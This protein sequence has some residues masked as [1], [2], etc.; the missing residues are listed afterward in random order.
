MHYV[1]VAQQAVVEMESER[2]R[3]ALLAAISHDVRTPLTALIGA[4]R[5]AA[6]GRAAADRDAARDWRSAIVDAGARNCNALVSNLL[7]MAR[8]RSGAVSLNCSATGNRSRRSW[9]RPSARP[10]ALA[11]TPVQT[12]LPADLP[13]V[14][15]DAVLIE[16]VLVN[17]L[18]NAAK[19]A[20]GRRSSSAPRRP[21]MRW[22]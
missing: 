9:A 7:D 11:D 12:E 6:D 16:R 20:R 8:L 5:V 10:A 14:E 19:Y 13:L 2:L 1:D 21:T 17:L 4:G 3:N 18:E 22:C 15:F